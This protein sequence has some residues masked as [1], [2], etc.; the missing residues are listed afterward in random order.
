M[1]DFH[2][3]GHHQ[4]ARL[5]HVHGPL[6]V[7]RVAGVCSNSP[8]TIVQT[9]GDIGGRKMGRGCA[10]RPPLTVVRRKTNIL[11]PPTASCWRRGGG[12][13]PPYEEHHRDRCGGPGTPL[14]IAAARVKWRFLDIV[15]GAARAK[16]RQ[17]C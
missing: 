11:F 3:M 4:D 13:D 14:A 2:L 8:E 5:G 12:A 6:G 10:F 17:I 1:R 9:P 15:A 7:A 16:G